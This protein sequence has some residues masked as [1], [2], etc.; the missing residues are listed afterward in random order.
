MSIA[1]SLAITTAVCLC[2][3]STRLI[4]VLGLFLCVALYPVASSVFLVAAG[5][6]YARFIWRK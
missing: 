3:A 1:L 2:F 6:F 4:G 5:I